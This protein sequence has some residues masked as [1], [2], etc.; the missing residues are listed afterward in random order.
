MYWSWL[1]RRLPLSAPESRGPSEPSTD[2]EVTTARSRSAVQRPVKENPEP[3][4]LAP[5]ATTRCACS[6]R[7]RSPF[8]RAPTPK[9]PAIL[10]L[11]IPLHGHQHPEQAIAAE[12]TR[13]FAVVGHVARTRVYHPVGDQPLRERGP[14]RVR[15][16]RE[17]RLVRPALADLPV[18]RA[19]ERPRRCVTCPPAGSSTSRRGPPST[20]AARRLRPSGRPCGS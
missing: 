1:P 13:P 4:G 17:R 9:G 19:A 15:Q 16:I 5:T 11:E 2:R 10:A 18:R 20:R 14:H 3:L 8:G 6:S 12:H 7:G